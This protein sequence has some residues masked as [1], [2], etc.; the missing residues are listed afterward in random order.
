MNPLIAYI[1]KELKKG[2]S[3]DLIAKKLKTAGYTSEE[4]FEAFHTYEIHRLST[5]TSK[6]KTHHPHLILFTIIG[7]GIIVGI[8]LTS[9][10]LQNSI[11]GIFS[12]KTIT[13]EKDCKGLAFKEKEQC[14]LQLAALYDDTAF[15]TNIT[16]KVM[17]Y[18]C[19]TQVWNKNYC[20]YL[21]LTDQPPC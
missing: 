3:K 18:E 19:K 10:A 11:K 20:N 7:I 1:D 6:E 13:T 2:F 15:C 8:L 17:K 4:I 5:G 16:S 12:E 14:L 21:I 9:T